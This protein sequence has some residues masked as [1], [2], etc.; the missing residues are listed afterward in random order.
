MFL[1]AW[2]LP[3][4]ARKDAAPVLRV[5][6]CGEARGNGDATVLPPLP[7]EKADFGAVARRLRQVQPFCVLDTWDCWKAA[8]TKSRSFLASM[9][10]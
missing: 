8:Q 4:A 6:A 3:E 7:G 5:N 10:A 2:V 1:F 9:P